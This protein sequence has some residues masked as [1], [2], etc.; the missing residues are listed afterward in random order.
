[1]KN[2]R[3]TP[4]DI[5]LDDEISSKDKTGETHSPKNYVDEILNINME[6]NAWK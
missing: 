2:K 4:L 6:I 3:V 1:M 5:S